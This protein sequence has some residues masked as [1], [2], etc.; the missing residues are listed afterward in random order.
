MWLITE[1]HGTLKNANLIDI[2]R[3]FDVYYFYDPVM[4]NSPA[5]MFGQW[6]TRRNT[7]WVKNTL[8]KGKN[9]IFVK[10]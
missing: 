9:D 5:W 2:G 7:A 10:P 3:A 8:V 1:L 6:L 4:R